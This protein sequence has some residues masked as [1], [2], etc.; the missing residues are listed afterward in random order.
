MS[1]E[2]LLIWQYR[3]K[4]KAVKTVQ[5]LSGFFMEDFHALHQ[6]MNV[7]DIDT[8]TG[9]NLDLVGKHVG[10]NRIVKNY[11]TSLKKRLK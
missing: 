11:I 5:F 6:M 4:P 3:N 9:K 2:N 7:L 8:A 1:Y 10:E